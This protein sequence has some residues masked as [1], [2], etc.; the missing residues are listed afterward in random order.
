MT[1]VALIPWREQAACRDVDP[2]V[3]FPA[4]VEGGRPRAGEE[5]LPPVE[6]RTPIAVCADCP[7][8]SACLDYA[9]RH[10]DQG[11]WGGTTPRQRERMRRALGIQLELPQTLDRLRGIVWEAVD[12]DG[13][14]S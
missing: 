14:A 6:W 13:E 7:V 9:L 1:A 12:V 8:R 11:V 10:E 5:L 4:G 3:F 2:D